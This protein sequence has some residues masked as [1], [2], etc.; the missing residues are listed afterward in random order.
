MRPLVAASILLLLP[1]A[2]PADAPARIELQVGE[3]QPITGFRP[4]CDDPSIVTIT[5]AGKGTVRGLKAGE[6][7]CSLST[8]SPLG[9]RSV[10]RVI[11]KER[12]GREGGGRGGGAGE[13]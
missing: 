11:V 1:A 7:T 4:L 5:A 8:G 3:E 12:R 10:F 9:Q 6:T 2:A 13:G